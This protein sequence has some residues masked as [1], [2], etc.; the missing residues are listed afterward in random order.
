MN[1]DI[2]YSKNAEMS[3]MYTNF[4]Y[5]ILNCCLLYTLLPSFKATAIAKLVSGVG[6]D[7]E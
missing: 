6:W 5:S 3:N 2:Q 7:W 4:I 1:S